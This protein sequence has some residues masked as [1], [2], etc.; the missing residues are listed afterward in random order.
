MNK[1]DHSELSRQPKELTFAWIRGDE[2]LVRFWCALVLAMIIVV[3]AWFSLRVVVP[4]SVAADRP[5]VKMAQLVMLDKNSHPSLQRLLASQNLPSLGSGTLLDE[6]PP[7]EDVL[8]QLGLEEQRDSEMSLYPAPE[9]S[10]RLKWPSEKDVELALPPLPEISVDSWPR[11][12]EGEPVEWVLRIAGSGP[13]GEFVTGHSFSWK[14]PV[15]LAR[16]STW[17]VATDGEGKLALVVP[18]GTVEKK[19]EQQVRGLWQRFFETTRGAP[20]QIAEQL[21]LTFVEKGEE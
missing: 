7:L 16:K 11:A 20:A 2:S 8:T 18:A 13:L 1:R 5:R 19:V 9:V 10:M 12:A 21:E 6:T 4:V 14:G 17:L 15:P 3:V